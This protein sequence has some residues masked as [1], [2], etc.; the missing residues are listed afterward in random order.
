MSGKHIVG[1]EG[2]QYVAR[3]LYEEGYLIL[4]RNWR[5]KPYEVDLIVYR[6]D[7]LI[8]VEVKTR[9]DERFGVKR[10]GMTESKKQALINA[11]Y[12][13]MEKYDWDTEFRFDVITIAKVANEWEVKHFKDAFFPG[14]SG[15]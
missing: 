7:T 10:W 4:E 11:G 3:R 15:L 12:F 9:T 8:F 13:Y 5:Q 2:E 6:A 1:G 14:I